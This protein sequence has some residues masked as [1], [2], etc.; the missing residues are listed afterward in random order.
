MDEEVRAH[1]RANGQVDDEDFANYQHR[2]RSQWDW[3]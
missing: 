3:S 1:Y 2:H